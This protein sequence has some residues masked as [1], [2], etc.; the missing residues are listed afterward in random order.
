MS[1]VTDISEL[2]ELNKLLDAQWARRKAADMD[3]HS[4]MDEIESLNNRIAAVKRRQAAAIPVDRSAVQLTDGSPVPSDR[5][6]TEDRG[7]GQ[8]RGYIVLSDAERA[9]GFVRPVRDSYRHVGTPP[10]KFQLKDLTPEQVER[11]GV[12]GYVKFEPYPNGHRGSSSGRYWT[13]ADLDKCSKGCGAVTTMG[14]A[15][16]ETYARDPDF[17]SGTFCTRCG[18][19]FPVGADGEF[20]W[21]E[22]DGREMERV[23]T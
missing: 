18:T 4:A 17:Y 8:Q 19:H 22:H 13:Q 5:S 9:K 2:A 10:P 16:A 1:N 6:H 20:V 7:D 21:I 14:R 12:H 11:V 23:G 3:A 15:L